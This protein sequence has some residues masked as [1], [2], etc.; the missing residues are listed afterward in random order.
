ML[1]AVV[2]ALEIQTGCHVITWLCTSVR[3]LRSF[4]FTLLSGDPIEMFFLSLSHL[5][6]PSPRNTTT[7]LFYAPI[8]STPHSD[9][10]CDWT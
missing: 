3:R 6:Y 1:A 4:R 5:Y 8:L 7:S 9:V 2:A 10:A